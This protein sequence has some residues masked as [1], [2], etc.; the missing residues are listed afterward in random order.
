ML[1]TLSEVVEP[2]DRPRRPP[3]RAGIRRAKVEALEIRG[4]VDEIG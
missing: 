4:V 1:V 3:L 2:M